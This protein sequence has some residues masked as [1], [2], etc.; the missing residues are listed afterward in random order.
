[1]SKRCSIFKFPNINFH[2]TKKEFDF[3]IYK[4]DLIGVS[5]F[6]EENVSKDDIFNEKGFNILL[7][8]MKNGE[9]HELV[10]CY[11][12]HIPLNF[13]LNNLCSYSLLHVLDPK[14]YPHACR[15]GNSC[16]F[17]HLNRHDINNI[18]GY[19][20]TRLDNGSV[21]ICGVVLCEF[22]THEKCHE[23]Y[24]GY[25]NTYYSK[26][27]GWDVESI[28]DC[29]FQRTNE[30]ILPQLYPLIIPD[31]ERRHRQELETGLLFD[32]ISPFIAGNIDESN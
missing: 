29:M 17:Y 10:E 19:L 30:E 11:E 12:Y 18:I 13:G 6:E 4:K 23:F 8:D 2:F 1:M 31:Y 15:H 28:I 14:R 25:I 3:R 5:F 7:Q 22:N 27:N 32:T 24:I 9:E 21:I 16:K 26:T 20:T